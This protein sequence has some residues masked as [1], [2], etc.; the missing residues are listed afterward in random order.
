MQEGQI[1]HTL[2]ASRYTVSRALDRKF[3]FRKPTSRPTAAIN[4]TLS[5]LRVHTVGGSPMQTWEISDRGAFDSTNG[6][7]RRRPTSRCHRGRSFTVVRGLVCLSR[8]TCRPSEVRASV[9]VYTRNPC[10]RQPLSFSSKWRVS[11]L[12][13]WTIAAGSIEY[14]SYARLSVLNGLCCFFEAGQATRKNRHLHSRFAPP[15]KRVKWL[16]A[17][18]TMSTAL[19]VRYP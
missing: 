17:I 13:G 11:L 5:A 19:P 10:G 1:R 7:A 12:S 4:H 6:E 15:V 16:P 3:T 8:A 14:K 2:L 9:V 18:S